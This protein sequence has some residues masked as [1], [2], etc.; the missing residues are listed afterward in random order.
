MAQ[1]LKYLVVPPIAKHTATVIF[2]HGL[3]DTGHGWKPVADMLSPTMPHVKWILPHAPQQ[4]VTANF[5]MIMPSWF[6]IKDF[7]FNSAEDERGMLTSVRMLE[8]VIRQE[9]ESGLDASRI[10][11]G[12]FSQGG[13]MSLLGGLTSERKL[14]GVVV[15]SA[16][17]PLHAKFKAMMSG[18]AK[19]LPI[20]WGHGTADPLVRF[21]FA[22]RSIEYLVGTC[23]LTRL[24]R[25]KIGSPGLTFM[26]Y[27][28]VQHSSSEKE[29]V[30]MGRFLK[31]VV[32]EE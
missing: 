1:E 15:L 4:S 27:Q 17:L 14:G 24:D 18:H 23:G 20:F 26:E 16:W 21:E 8:G 6:D 13:V 31:R 25:D 22:K 7:S 9:V 10:V 12:G 29:L 32:P 3:G 11:L 30:D 2:V 5:G 19:S 28:G